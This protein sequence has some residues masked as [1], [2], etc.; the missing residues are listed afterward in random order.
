MD[1]E[2]VDDNGVQVQH[3]KD[4]EASGFS[5]SFLTWFRYRTASAR[6]GYIDRLDFLPKQRIEAGESFLGS[7]LTFS[8]VLLRS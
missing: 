3:T 2:L 4:D 7:G 5:T 1:S 6:K 8:L